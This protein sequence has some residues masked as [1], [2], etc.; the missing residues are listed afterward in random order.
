MMNVKQREIVV[1]A[2]RQYIINAMR[3]DPV[4]GFSDINDLFEELKESDDKLR[5][6]MEEMYEETPENL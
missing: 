2:Y 5:K 6:E 3:C 4:G 1:D